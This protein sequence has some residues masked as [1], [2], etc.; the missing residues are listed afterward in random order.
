[1]PSLDVYV[2]YGLYIAVPVIAGLMLYKYMKGTKTDKI[3]KFIEQP[4]QETFY[5]ALKDKVNQFGVDMNKFKLVR[6][7]QIVGYPRK[8]MLIDIKMPK[9]SL[10]PKTKAVK[11]KTEKEIEANK[12][13][14]PVETRLM[15]LQSGNKNILLRFLHLKNRFFVIETKGDF[16]GILKIEAEKRMLTIQGLIDL[17]SFGDVWIMSESGHE[18]MSNIS[19]KRALEQN[20]MH[21][22]NMAD[23]VVHYDIQQAKLERRDRITTE[24]EKTKYEERKSQGDSTIV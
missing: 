3:E 19:I 17:D 21:S 9:F 18:Y 7:Y 20:L 2:M 16:K 6:D 24:L 8:Y 13:L 11:V 4:L 15:I 14:S 5:E 1:M 22:E 12:D 10:D 23:R